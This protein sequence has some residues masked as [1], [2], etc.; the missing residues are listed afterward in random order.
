M[1]ETKYGKYIITGARAQLFKAPGEKNLEEVNNVLV[2]NLD[3]SLIKGAPLLEAAWLM[4]EGFDKQFE[5]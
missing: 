5:M 4:P 3:D 2:A 1:A